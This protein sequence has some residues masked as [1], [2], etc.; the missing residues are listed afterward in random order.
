MLK[1]N[2]QVTLLYIQFMRADIDI[3]AF[4]DITIYTLLELRF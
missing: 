4:Q 2:R 1:I 3:V